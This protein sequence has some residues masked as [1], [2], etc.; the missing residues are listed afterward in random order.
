M[1]LFFLD[2]PDLAG[3]FNVGTGQARSWN[4]LAAAVFAA[5]GRPAAID[6]IEMPDILRDKY[7]YYTCAEM[8]KLRGAGYDRPTMP[9][10]EAVKDYVQKY[11]AQ[12]QYLGV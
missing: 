5:M 12:G 8:A 1:S 9:M 4:D 10:E 6:Y 3:I 7:Q 11:L 2:R